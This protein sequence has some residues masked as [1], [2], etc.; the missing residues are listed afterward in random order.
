MLTEDFVSYEVARL[1][2]EKGF[3]ERTCGVYF[4]DSD[5][6]FLISTPSYH[7]KSINAIAAPTH[8]MAMKWLREEKGIAIIPVLSSVLDNEKFLWDIKIVVAKTHDIYY[9]GWT[10]EKQEAACETAIKYCLTNLI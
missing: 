6:T 9:Q 8:Q 10:Y 3:D 7:N 5:E 2:K 4:D 1:F